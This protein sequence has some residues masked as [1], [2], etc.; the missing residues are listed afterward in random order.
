MTRPFYC[1]RCGLQ[2]R[3]CLQCYA[4]R[5]DCRMEANVPRH[6]D[7][8]GAPYL[9]QFVREKPVREP[10]LPLWRREGSPT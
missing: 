1:T 5:C 7:E 4:W 3:R 10:M 9:V 8:S 2:L 6:Y